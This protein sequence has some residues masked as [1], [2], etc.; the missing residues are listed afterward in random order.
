MVSDLI[1]SYLGH[2]K[3]ATPFLWKTDPRLVFYVLL[4]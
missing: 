3:G 1:G 2:K 4:K